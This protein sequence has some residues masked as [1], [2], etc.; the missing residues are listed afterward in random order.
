MMKV[1]APVG[2]LLASVALLLMGNGLQGTLLPLRAEI[3]AFSPVAIGVMGSS[4][5]LGFALGCFYGPVVVG[6]VGHIRTFTAAA[7]LASTVALAHA[8]IPLAWAWWPLRA[9]TGFAFAILYMVIESW[10]NERA[11][12]ETRGTVMSI[13]TVINLTVIMA[14]Q[15]LLTVY[16]PASF[17]PFALA[18][19]LVSL[20]ALP[21]ALSTALAPAPLHS[22]KVRFVRLYRISPVGFMGAFAVGLGNGAF[23]SLAPLFATGSGLGVGGVATFMSLVVLGG[24]I[25]QYPL[26]KLSDRTDRRRVILAAAIGV[27]VTG[28]LLP[29]VAG[30]FSPGLYIGAFLFGLTAMP[31]YSLSVAHMNDFVEPDG[32][33]EASSGM[34]MVY[35]AGAIAGPMIASWATGLIGTDLLFPYIAVVYLGF[36]A[37]VV[38]RMRARAAPAPDAR[39]DFVATAGT[40]PALSAL[41]PRSDSEATPSQTA[42]SQAMEV[43]QEGPVEGPADG[44]AGTTAAAADG[45]DRQGDS[46]DD[47]GMVSR[48]PPEQA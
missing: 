36:A 32:F 18:S 21:I 22:T 8:L 34:L 27:V 5:F 9:L 24:A 30:L 48:P 13:Y 23:W 40:S 1:V 43:A 19:I 37:F 17:P 20:A 4:Y 46:T 3:E 47:R 39:P 26:G 14:G 45:G 2:A 33:V 7:A 16:D 25:G 12:N 15:M 28:A 41:D 10:L 42:A 11:T 31:V 35:A 6:R 38:L 44:A 29:V